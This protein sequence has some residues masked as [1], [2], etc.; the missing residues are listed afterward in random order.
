MSI[1]TLGPEGTY[2]HQ[3]ALKYFPEGSINF[4][5]SIGEVFDMISSEKNGYGIIPLENM[6]EG[7]VRETLDLLYETEVK[8][9]DLVTLPIHHCLA[10]T[11]EEFEIITSHKQ[12]LAQCRGYLKENY[13]KKRIQAVNSTAEATKLASEHAGLAAICSP[14]AAE[15]YGLT[16]LE[17]NIED[18]SNNQTV[19][20]VIHGKLNPDQ[21]LKTSIAITPEKDEPGL[22]VKMLYPFQENE[23]NMTRLESR[24]EK[25]TMNKYIFFID[26]EGDFRQARA[27][28]IFT[29]LEKDL[30]L[31]SI[32][33]LGG[34]TSSP[35]Q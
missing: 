22:L 1:F 18:F 16:I 4:L 5:D 7:T 34:Q 13:K 15:K 25:S 3:A 17:E 32:K 26:F 9:W 6:I 11:S 21:H 31:C 14:F 23:V 30:G 29:Y 2:A 24:P 28:K 19:F 35:D 27:R 33:V 20:A 10:S 12:A 8:I